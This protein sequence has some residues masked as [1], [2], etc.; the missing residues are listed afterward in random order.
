MNQAEIRQTLFKRQHQLQQ[1]L[2]SVE[3]DLQQA[4]SQDWS[5]QALERENDQ[6]LEAIA[7]ETAMELAQ[8]KRVLK[9]MTG[10]SYGICSECGQPI[11]SE[12]LKAIPSAELCIQ[13]ASHH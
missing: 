3:H 4:H 7:N 1:R 12:R 9:K 11:N 5:E 2:E 10:H 13:C 6:V 8:L